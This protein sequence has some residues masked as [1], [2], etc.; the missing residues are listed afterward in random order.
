MVTPTNPIP[1]NGAVKLTLPNNISIQHS[2]GKT[3]EEKLKLLIDSCSIT[4]SAG[5]TGIDGY[6]IAD[7]D[8]FAD[9]WGEAMSGEKG[10]RAIW[11]IG[12][13]VDQ[14]WYTS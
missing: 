6:C 13:F 12:A 10:A 11:F 4:T 9:G 7:K 1:M 14:E 2:E 3:N 8:Y 5:Y